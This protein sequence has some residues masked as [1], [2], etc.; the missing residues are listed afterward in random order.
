MESNRPNKCQQHS[1]V[2]GLHLA[3]TI[4]IQRPCA[5]W[6]SGCAAL[7]SPDLARQPGESAPAPIIIGESISRERPGSYLLITGNCESLPLFMG[8]RC[9]ARLFLGADELARFSLSA[10]SFY[11]KGPGASR[12]F[13]G[14]FMGL[15]NCRWWWFAVLECGRRAIV[16]CRVLSGMSWI[17]VTLESRHFVLESKKNVADILPCLRMSPFWSWAWILVENESLTLYKKVFL[18][19]LIARFNFEYKNDVFPMTF[20]TFFIPRFSPG[21]WLKLKNDRIV[22][23][24]EKSRGLGVPRVPIISH[25]NGEHNRGIT[26]SRGI[27]DH[28]LKQTVDL[29]RTANIYRKSPR[30]AC[31][32]AAKRPIHAMCAVYTTWERCNSHGARRQFLVSLPAMTP[33]WAHL[34]NSL[35]YQV[36]TTDLQYELHLPPSLCA[37][38]IITTI[39]AAAARLVSFSSFSLMHAQRYIARESSRARPARRGEQCANNWRGISRA[40]Y[41]E[42]RGSEEL[43]AVSHRPAGNC[44]ARAVRNEGSSWWVELR[45]LE[46]PL[47]LACILLWCKE[48]GIEMLNWELIRVFD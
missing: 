8:H 10:R 37:R 2:A 9:G 7:D 29:S 33:S 25:Q 13:D 20:G 39:V 24:S 3:R 31:I 38:D 47:L 36:H 15:E 22:A 32:P 18:A 27:A 23:A 30:Y 6:K 34:R 4:I 16:L 48:F 44:R 11:T 43:S 12:A 21:S 28:A 5:P 14:R 19:W 35:A 26:H 45:L 17:S 46:K 1:T 41:W 40:S 42:A